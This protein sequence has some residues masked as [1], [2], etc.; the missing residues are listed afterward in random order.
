M[1]AMFGHHGVDP[2]EVFRKVEVQPRRWIA[3]VDN[4]VKLGAAAAYLRKGAQGE[5]ERN[6]VLKSEDKSFQVFLGFAVKTKVDNPQKLIRL[7]P[8]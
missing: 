2:V 7:F 3:D 4:A 1:E 8:R 5:L 6:Q